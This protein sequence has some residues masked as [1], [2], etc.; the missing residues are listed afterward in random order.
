MSIVGKLG[1]R[2]KDLNVRYGDRNKRRLSPIE[3]EQPKSAKVSRWL[4][5]HIVENGQKELDSLLC[6][7]PIFEM[8][9]CDWKP[10]PIQWK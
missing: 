2:I 3:E 10:I 5:N 6:K 4:K 8:T 7:L 9:Q 1:S